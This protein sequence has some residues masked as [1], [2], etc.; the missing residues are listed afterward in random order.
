MQRAWIRQ[1]ALSLLCSISYQEGA[2]NS[3]IQAS[4]A[5][6]VIEREKAFGI[7]DGGRSGERARIHSVGSYVDV[8]N[9]WAQVE[10][11]QKLE[12]LDGPFHEHFE[13]CE[14]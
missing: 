7:E 10:M 6:V 5:Q 11:T 14:W 1:R 3:K 4:I 12:G 9:R 2:W 8:E 13:W